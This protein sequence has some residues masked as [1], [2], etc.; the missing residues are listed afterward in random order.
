MISLK[1]GGGGG[2]STS[3]RYKAP[4]YLSQGNGGF[5]SGAG[6]GAAASASSSSSSLSSSTDASSASSSSCPAST[7]RNILGAW[8]LDQT[9]ESHS[10]P[11]HGID[12]HPHLP[13]VATAS[14]DSVCHIYDLESRRP[15]GE[16]TGGH[17]KGWVFELRE[18]R[19]R[20]LGSWERWQH[21]QAHH[22][23]RV[24]IWRRRR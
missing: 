21:S 2:D 7:L 23:V 14:W 13:V 12:I 19:D 5:G 10:D 6:A 15:I 9:F 1:K 18:N 4:T 22:R 11:V 20:L 3:G 24:L 8:K 17:R 16:L